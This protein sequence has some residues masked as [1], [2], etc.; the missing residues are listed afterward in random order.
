M[1]LQKL[2]SGGNNG[3]TAL[4]FACL[5]GHLA[6]VK[7]L[8]QSGADKNRQTDEG[9]TPLTISCVSGHL[10]VVRYLLNVAGADANLAMLDNAA[11]PLILTIEMGNPS[12][13]ECLVKAGANVNAI[14]REG[15]SALQQAC[16]RGNAKIVKCLLDAGVD[17]NWKPSE[18]DLRRAS[19]DVE[20][21]Y[22]KRGSPLFIACED[23]SDAIVKLLIERGANISW[24]DS[25]RPERTPLNVACERG[26][27]STLKLLLEMGKGRI[28]VSSGSFHFACSEGHTGIIR[29][30]L[31]H[32]ILAGLNEEK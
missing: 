8:I 27:E 29:L 23:G 11:P 4:Q 7:Y 1:F 24:N 20:D 3:W 19:A 18:E 28:E 9:V 6:V 16:I 26:R 17:P 21:G 14:D 2:E 31:R 25:K 32:G 5:K 30:L 13:V 22:A 15:I 12:M 10:D